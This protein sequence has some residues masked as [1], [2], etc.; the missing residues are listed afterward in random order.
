MFV[1]LRDEDGNPV[2]RGRN[3]EI[4]IGGATLIRNI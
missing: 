2:A 1:E 4:H 3:R